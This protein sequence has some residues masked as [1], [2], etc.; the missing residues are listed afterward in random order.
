MTSTPSTASSRP[1]EV[2]IKY[3]D[4]AR[5]VPEVVDT[6]IL[7]KAAPEVTKRVIYAPGTSRTSTA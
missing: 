3:A 6:V 2:E 4:P 7:T 1:I 5:K